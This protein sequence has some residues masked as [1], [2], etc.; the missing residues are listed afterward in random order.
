M[1]FSVMLDD[2]PGTLAR[3]LGVIAQEQGNILHIYHSTGEN[4]LP[5]LTARVEIELETRGKDHSITIKKKL[6]DNGYEI[7][8]L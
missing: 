5:I 1:H 6:A 4:D 7:R 8:L 2:H 3:L